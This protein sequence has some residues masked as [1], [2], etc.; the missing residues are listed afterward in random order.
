MSDGLSSNTLYGLVYTLIF[1]DVLL[2]LA[3][4]ASI[5]YLYTE[6]PL[7]LTNHAIFAFY[8]LQTF[9]VINV[10]SGWN[11]SYGKEPAPIYWLSASLLSFFFT[12]TIFLA[13][14]APDPPA[15][16]CSQKLLNQILSGTGLGISLI[17]LIFWTVV[18]IMSRRVSTTTKRTKL[19]DISSSVLSY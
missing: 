4:A 10:L 3:W 13:Q 2:F 5:F 11:E 19:V 16:G 8:F 1:L 18:R 9:A 17:S 6:C 7:T 14:F 12:L 15:L